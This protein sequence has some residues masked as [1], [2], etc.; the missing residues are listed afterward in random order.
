MGKLLLKTHDGSGSEA[1]SPTTRMTIDQSGNV[2]IGSTAPDKTLVVQADDAEIVLNDNN[3]A[4]LF[5][6]RE[7]GVTKGAIGTSAGALI[8]DSGGDTERMRIDATGNVGIG[9]TSPDAIVHLSSTLG[10]T[11]RIESTATSMVAGNNI[12]KIQFEGQDT[13]GAGVTAAI[14]AEVLGSAGQT[15]LAFDT[16]SGGASAQR[17]LLDQN[18]NLLVGKTATGAATAGIELNGSN[19]LL[20]I[21]RDGGVLQELNRIT[22][23]G[24]L[25]DFRKDNVSVGSIATQSG[26]ICLMADSGGGIRVRSAMASVIPV[27]AARTNLDDT[28]DLGSSGA[29]FKD[30]YLS[31]GAY[32]GGTAAANKLDDYEEGTF[33]VTT[34]SDATGA[35]SNESGTYTK[36]GD[37][38][39]IDIAF[40]VGTNFT[41]NLIGG[42]PF[43]ASVATTSS[44]ARPIQL[45]IDNAIGTARYLNGQTILRLFDASGNAVNPSTTTDPFRISGVYRAA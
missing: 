26:E 10:T 34:Y 45:M 32:L 4:P 2:G 36:I 41:S 38:V 8:F 17:M 16:G 43:T 35:F 20:R 22:N 18:G 5:R 9:T 11:L 33:T 6:F 28:T 30:L 7:S 15:G 42:L 40:I 29:R 3:D 14:R 37:L 44:S 39:F 23:D 12:G 31:G 27:N 24:D 19:D 25:I 21:A 13:E 1:G